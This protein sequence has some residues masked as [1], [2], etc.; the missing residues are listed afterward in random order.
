[1]AA[2]FIKR[3]SCLSWAPLPAGRGRH[4]D[5]ISRVVAHCVERIGCLM[6]GVI[7]GLCRSSLARCEQL[8][9]E[10]AGVLDQYMQRIDDLDRIIQPVAARTQVGKCKGLGR[11]LELQLAHVLASRRIV[12]LRGTVCCRECAHCVLPIVFAS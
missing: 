1:M 8:T 2:Q 6:P 11:P 7:V 3:M 12:E 4:D 10:A 5:A 9:G